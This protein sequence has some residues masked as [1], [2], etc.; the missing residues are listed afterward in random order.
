MNVYAITKMYKILGHLGYWSRCGSLDCSSKQ[1]EDVRLFGLNAVIQYARKWDGK[2]NVFISRNPRN[3]NGSVVSSNC[4]SFDCDPIRPK[5]DASNEEQ[6]DNALNAG[7]KILE[8]YPNGYLC[9]S[10]N[11][12]LL[13]YPSNIERST[14][15][16]YY[17]QEGVF[18]T[19]SLQPLMEG[20]NVKI[21]PTSYEEAMLKLIGSMSTKGDKAFHRLS[22]FI[23]F[24]QPGSVSSIQKSV[25]GVIV[26]SIEISNNA[27]FIGNP[28]ERI[29]EASKSLDRLDISFHSDYDKW[30]KVGMALKEFGIS[31]LQL[32]KEWS[33]KSEKYEEGK[34]EEKWKTFQESPEITLGSL[35][36]WA[37]ESESN[38]TILYEST[39]NQGSYFANLFKKDNN[40]TGVIK[41]GI[42][43]IDSILGS[44]PKGE[45]TTIAARSGFGKSSFACTVSEFLRQSNTKVLYFSTEM[46]SQYI[47]NK[48]VAIRT[49]ISL[50]RLMEKNFTEE[51]T[52]RIREYEQELLLSPIIICD[53]FSP[54]IELVKD[55]V[56]QHKPD[57]LVF[58]HA[59]QSG[60]HW[61]YIAQF[62]RGLK[63]I[64]SEYGLVTLLASQLNEPPRGSSGVVGTSVRGDIRGS[65]EVIFLSAI[66][67]MMNNIYEVKTDNQPVELEIC[68]NRYG[69]SGIKLELHCNK[70]T[71]KYQD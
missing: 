9:S 24:P 7:R 2:R 61:E 13:L 59:T 35:K 30:V 20:L 12:C 31:G 19:K 63:L 50:K 22:R 23:S 26:E 57:L 49:G 6:H 34:C 37:K 55:L 18:I 71:G 64:T 16:D 65:Q 39:P 47:L 11:G 67:M 43:I 44:L 42:S 32:W 33:K 25:E 58:D 5:G 10:G 48:F 41:T 1:Y 53:E 60:T 66:F 54:K 14:L 40:D 62:V 56:E 29:R 52:R 15:D 46:S 38:K 28:V 36:Y 21:D 45:I 69:L 27:R 8:V 68:K 17:K 70:A 4:I 51:E 3:E